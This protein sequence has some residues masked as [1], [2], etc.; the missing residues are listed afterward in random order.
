[1]ANGI[2]FILDGLN[3]DLGLTTKPT[4]PTSLLRLQ[5]IYLHHVNI[6]LQTLTI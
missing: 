6:I 4:F 3:T 5:D 1:M 2:N